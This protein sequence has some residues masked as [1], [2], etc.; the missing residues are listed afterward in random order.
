MSCRKFCVHNCWNFVYFSDKLTFP[1]HI[2]LISNVF[3]ENI[4]DCSFWHRNRS[5][6]N[7]WCFLGLTS[8][9]CRT[10][11]KNFRCS[12]ASI[13][14]A[15]YALILLCFHLRSLTPY[16][17]CRR[18]IRGLLKIEI[19]LSRY[20]QP[21]KDTITA[22]R[23]IFGVSWVFA[24]L[25]SEKYIARCLTTKAVSSNTLPILCK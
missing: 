16:D 15:F 23:F 10:F 2:R 22:C 11:W 19:S 4:S 14:N 7:S 9:V 5:Q 13:W 24:I 3:V 12:D 20:A 21:F 8:I 18:K 1:H 25:L 6:V 17:V